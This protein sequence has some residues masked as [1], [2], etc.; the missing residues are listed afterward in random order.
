MRDSIRSLPAM[1]VAGLAA[2]AVLGYLAGHA[3]TGA[4]SA[5]KM[6]TA[7][8]AGILLDYPSGWRA[9]SAA[10]VIPGLS[11]A[12]AVVLAPGGE[13]A[14]AG[15]VIGQLPAGEPTPLPR[16]FVAR[17]RSLP[18]TAVVALL[19][20][21]AYRYARLS[22]PGFDHM[23]TLFAIPN[24]AGNPTALAC[25]ASAA[26]SAYMRTC[27]RVVA[28]LTLV[29]QSQSYDLTPEPGYAGGLSTSIRAL[30]GQRL[31]LRREMSRGAAPAVV[32][33]LA[34][35]L[36]AGY[37]GAA[38][39]IS[40]LEPPSA[41]KQAQATL[42]ESILQARNAYAALA[43][44][45]QAENPSLSAAAGRGVYEAETSVN[46]ALENFTL[47]GYKA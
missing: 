2:V 24:P 21:Q 6:R 43:A 12:H 35:R 4:A 31:T 9:A 33:Q 29:G 47:L 23:L 19:E 25:Y 22:I 10:P 44:A 38:A 13:A 3:G 30:D 36:A 7:S 39:S 17:M 15:L 45:A 42:S 11:L 40:T 20:V 1:V 32:Q 28:A 8:V 41:T 37:A 46:A 34:S 26:L 16:Q 27:E 14:Q 18:D 5:Q